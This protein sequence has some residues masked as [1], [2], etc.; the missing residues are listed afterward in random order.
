MAAVTVLDMHMIV[1]EFNAKDISRSFKFSIASLPQP[2]GA[3]D[4]GVTGNKCSTPSTREYMLVSS[5]NGQS[6]IDIF[7]IQRVLPH[8]GKFASHFVGSR[9][10]SNGS[11][12]VASRMDPLFFALAH[13]DRTMSSKIEAE[14][15]GKAESPLQ[16]WQPW[17][18]AL[19]DLPPVILRALNLDP[20]LSLKSV[21]DAGQL[22]HLLDV[23]DMCGDDLI[24]CKFS[25]DRT[26]KWLVT[27]Y[28][29][30]AD[31]LRTRILDRKKREVQRRNIAT[32]SSDRG[33]NGA[34]SSSFNI[35]EEC[36]EIIEDEKKE[37]SENNLNQSEHLTLANEEEVSVKV[38]AMQLI[39]E[40]LPK[41]WAE[42]LSSN[43]LIPE[44]DWVG[45]KKTSTSSLPA[46]EDGNHN[47]TQSSGQKR[48]RSSWE[49]N[50]GQE[51]AD[52]LL[53]Y[54]LGSGG[55]SSSSVITPSGKS[56]VANAK[57]SG[58][59]RLAKVNTKGMK[60]LASFFGAPKKKK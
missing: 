28:E 12:H 56:E 55:T 31:A 10:V 36:Q 52:S 7:E 25:E 1:S 24:L 45:K 35:G 34:F 21:N 33:G 17:D 19:A 4:E 41:S 48:S 59:K 46:T 26:L 57:S 42:K 27:K 15:D 29:Q 18:Q 8:N 38:G 40:Y 5:R 51:D 9:V 50:L 60:S 39:G 2:G 54:T 37:E 22:A 14:S 53:Q 44:C 58:L 49:G 32:K 20:K 47:L 23:S 3:F 11:L 13:I 16:K 6:G 43:L 30:A